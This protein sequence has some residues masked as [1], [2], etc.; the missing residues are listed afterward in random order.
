[1]E[2]FW[3]WTWQRFTW[4]CWSSDQKVFTKGTTWCSWG[5]SLDYKRGGGFSMQAFVR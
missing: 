2:F 5:K 3:K 1:M 4:W